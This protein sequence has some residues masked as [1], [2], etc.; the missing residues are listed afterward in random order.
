MFKSDLDPEREDTE[1]PDFKDY[2]MNEIT[3]IV[4]ED[5]NDTKDDIP[6]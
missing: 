5:F 3:D 1:K 6:N 2:I 4:T